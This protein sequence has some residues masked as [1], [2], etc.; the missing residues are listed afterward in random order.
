MSTPPASSPV[1]RTWLTD[2][3]GV[4]V[5]VAAA[6]MAGVSGGGLAAAVS[7]AGGLGMVGIGPAADETWVGEQLRLA[8]APGR[9]YGVGL[10]AWS[11]PEQPAVLDL[12]LAAADDQPWQ[13][14]ALV[15]VSFGV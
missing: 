14:P 15:S 8:S 1:S 7:S 5:P 10:L 6:P 13:R 4:S 9:P 11:L 2:Q 3:L 12:L